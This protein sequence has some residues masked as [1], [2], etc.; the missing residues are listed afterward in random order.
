MSARDGVLAR[1]LVARVF[2]LHG[3]GGIAR[4]RRARG[5]TARDARPFT[6]EEES[7]LHAWCSIS[8]LAVPVS[9]AGARRRGAGAG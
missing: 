2:W 5:S 4:E 9:V 7:A 8:G 6:P 3:T 1:P